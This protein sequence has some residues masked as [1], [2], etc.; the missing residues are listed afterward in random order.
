MY[1]FLNRLKMFSYHRNGPCGFGWTRSFHNRSLLL[2]HKN[3]QRT[4]T[5]IFFRFG[6]QTTALTTNA[7]RVRERERAMRQLR[8]KSGQLLCVYMCRLDPPS[9]SPTPLARPHSQT[10]A[11]GILRHTH[12][13][14]LFACVPSPP[15][16]LSIP[17]LVYYTPDTLE[18]TYGPHPSSIAF[19]CVHQTGSRCSCCAKPN[20]PFFPFLF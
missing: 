20:L 1:F 17:M 9:F 18:C 7:M 4:H 11:R 13:H 8:L 5:T 10:N 2:T 12:T 19:L 6:T 3:T 14:S 16:L 15:P